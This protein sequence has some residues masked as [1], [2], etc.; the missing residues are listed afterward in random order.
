MKKAGMLSPTTDVEDLAKRAFVHLDGVSDEWLN[1]S[2]GRESRGRPGAPDQDIRLFAEL[3]LSDTGRC[4]LQA[5]MN[6]AAK[7]SDRSQCDIGAALNADIAKSASLARKQRQT[8]PLR[9]LLAVPVRRAFALGIHLVS[10]RKTSRQ[11]KAHSYSSFSASFFGAAISRGC[12]QLLVLGVATLDASHVLRSSPRRRAACASGKSSRR[13]F[14]W[15]PLPYFPG[16]AGV[17]QSLINDR[18]LALRQHLAFARPAA[19]GGYA[20]GVAIALVTGVCIGWFAPARY[21]GMPLLKVV[22][23]NSGHRLDSAGDGGFALGPI[24]RAVGLIALA[25][26]FPVTMLTASGI[27]NTRASYL[28]VAR[29]LGR[30]PRV[31]SFS[32]SP[33]RQRCR[34]FSSACSWDSARR[35]SRWSSPK[36]SA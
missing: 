13:V 28:D 35:F 24:S 36:R 20:L 5:A 31:I 12:M 6:F 7:G 25:V 21:W 2:A 18:E 15:L 29:T 19:F 9:I 27:S 32:A 17:L 33:F 4:M 30:E 10:L 34:A 3:I 26:W 14:T 1:Q 8:S 23:P 16:P 11:P 22:G